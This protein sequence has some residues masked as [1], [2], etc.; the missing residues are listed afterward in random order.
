MF[1]FAADKISITLK[2][3]DMKAYLFLTLFSCS[4]LSL[5]AQQVEKSDSSRSVNRMIA[6]VKSVLNINTQPTEFVD[7]NVAGRFT[8][9]RI[10]RDG[11]FYNYG[12]SSAISL[13]SVADAR[14]TSGLESII[15]PSNYVAPIRGYAVKGI[16]NGGMVGLRYG[17]FGS[18]GGEAGAA[19]YGTTGDDCG[20]VLDRPY[21]GYFN[22]DTKVAGALSVNGGV[23]GALLGKIEEMGSETPVGH[24]KYRLGALKLVSYNHSKGTNIS[25]IHPNELLPGTPYNS[26]IANQ[27]N[28]NTHYGL[29]VV[30]MPQMT[31]NLVYTDEN[32]EQ[33]LN[34]TDL[35][36]LIVSDLNELRGIVEEN[37]NRG[38]GAKRR[39]L[40][41]SSELSL[42]ENVV[43][44]GQNSPNPFNTQTSIS[45]NI[46]QDVQ[47][48]TLYVYDLNGK[49]IKS[50]LLDERGSISFTIS[51]KEFE[52]G[53]YLYSLI[54]DGVVSGT[55]RMIVTP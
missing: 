20:V 3:L 17:L 13:S 51:A 33:Y 9:L 46:P 32:G 35:I 22:G 1:I 31:S 47:Q 41:A 43:T 49:Q 34:Y 54:A 30:Y 52:A 15:L 11:R 25:R 29:K 48:A 19:V 26:L 10:T 53:I 28:A 24:A 7:V 40:D 50:Y 36:P 37:L 12:A 18:F 44:I 5:L 6:P 8:P 2:Y 45:L 4:V 21:A 16:S 38:S 39:A 27:S 42:L 23:H 55:Q 14:S